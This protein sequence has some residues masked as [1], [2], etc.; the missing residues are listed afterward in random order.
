M[1]NDWVEQ[2]RQKI[3]E[4]EKRLAEMKARLVPEQ[5]DASVAEARIPV[6]SEQLRRRRYWLVVALAFINCVHLLNAAYRVSTGPRSASLILPREQVTGP[7]RCGRQGS[8][9]G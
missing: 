9:Q 4:S 7:P 1:S 3:T 5:S 8:I 6:T 2:Q